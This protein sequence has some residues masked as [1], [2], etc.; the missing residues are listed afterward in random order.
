MSA[1]RRGMFLTHTAAYMFTLLDPTLQ[2]GQKKRQLLH[3]MK[4]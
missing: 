1:N 4:A 2:K 3:W